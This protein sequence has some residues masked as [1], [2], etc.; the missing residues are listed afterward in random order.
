LGERSDGN[1]R[2]R[3]P[4]GSRYG[5]PK[6]PEEAH[7]PSSKRPIRP[8]QTSASNP[9]RL[10]QLEE[11]AVSSALRV[12]QSSKA[13]ATGGCPWAVGGQGSAWGRSAHGRDMPACLKVPT[14]TRPIQQCFRRDV[15]VPRSQPIKSPNPARLLQLEDAHGLPAKG[16]S[17]DA[18]ANA[19]NPAR[20]M[21]LEDVAVPRS[22]PF[23]SSSS[24][25]L[26]MH[27]E[28]VMVPRSQAPRRR[29][30]S[31]HADAIGGCGGISARRVVYPQIFQ[32]HGRSPWDV[33]S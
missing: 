27:L 19:P 15:A 17:R 23:A 6:P 24:P 32:A 31:C 5:Q 29:Y 10:L 11:V 21:Q 13:Y 16:L 30:E 25:A 22:Q 26:L 7:G 4:P 18:H 9:A 8:D 14:A 20:L 2:S 12:V 1:F 33:T 3:T 28:G